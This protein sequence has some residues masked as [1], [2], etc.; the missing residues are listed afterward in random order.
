[1]ATDEQISV[2]CDIA[3]SG[4]ADLSASKI[5]ALRAIVA[6]GLIE[7]TA[8]DETIERYKLTSKGQ[9]LLDDRGVGANES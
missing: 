9:K 8:K 7:P 5:A 4:G 6:D 2:M 1:M 3:S